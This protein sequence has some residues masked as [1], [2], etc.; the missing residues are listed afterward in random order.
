MLLLQEA[1]CCGW[2]TMLM[3]VAV[4]LVRLLALELLDT[5]LEGSDVES[6]F[7]VSVC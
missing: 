5:N 2:C 6:V 7:Q 3:L 4:L 1:A